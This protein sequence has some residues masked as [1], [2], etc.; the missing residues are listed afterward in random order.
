MLGTVLGTELGI[1]DGG[2][3]A[4]PP[5]GAGTVL[6]TVEGGCIAPP[7]AGGGGVVFAREIEA[8]TKTEAR[9][10]KAKELPKIR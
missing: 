3:I 2:C 4:P 8:G 5:A 10:A 7:P 9:T 1:V 6:G